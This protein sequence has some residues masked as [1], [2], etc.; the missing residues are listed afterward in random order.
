MR[1]IVIRNRSNRQAKAS[2]NEEK[3]GEQKGNKEN[4]ELNESACRLF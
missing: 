4:K 1:T 3:R 2:T